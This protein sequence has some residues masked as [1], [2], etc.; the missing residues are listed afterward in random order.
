MKKIRQKKKKKKILAR[1]IIFIILDLFAFMGFFIM[2]GP[3]DYVRNLYVTTAMN[4][5]EHQWMAKIFYSDDMIQNIINGN[6]FVT[7]NDDV[8]TDDIVI[9]TKEKTNYKDE[10]ERELLTRENGNDLY[11]VISLKVGSAA[12]LCCWP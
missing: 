4:T 3:I 10:Y 12:A 11:K 6:Y 1:T 5:M 7:I 9:D 2:Y 8:N